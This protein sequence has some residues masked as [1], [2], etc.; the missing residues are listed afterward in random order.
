[1]KHIFRMA[2]IAAFVASSAASNAQITTLEWLSQTIDFGAFNEENGRVT[3]VLKAV[4]TGNEPLV[5]LDA[6]ANCG[7][8]VP[9]Y[10]PEPVAPGDTVSISVSYDPQG[11]P[12]RFSKKVYVDTNTE[13]S[14]S[15]LTIKGVVIGAPSSVSR[16][17]PV[18]MGPVSFERPTALLGTAYKGHVKSVFMQGYNHSTRTL[19][20]KVKC[21]VS[22]VDVATVQDSVGP[23]EQFSLNFFI[24]PDRTPLYGVVADTVYIVP[25]V[26]NPAESFAMPVVV[27]L[28]DDFSKITEEELA[29]APQAVYE[30]STIHLGKM[31]A[32]KEVTAE[33]FI[34]N[35]GKEPLIIRRVYSTNPTAEFTLD[36][37]K[38]K[39]GKSGK[40]IVSAKMPEDG[41]LNLRITAITNDPLNPTTIL[42]LT[43]EQY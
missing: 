16:R 14:R 1:M 25:E 18:E 7:C 21:A 30:N 27:T 29:R 37:K 17:Y 34:Q 12:G 35:K 6:R 19:R 8:T 24:S 32:G 23:G 15:T 2:A 10:S 28:E 9:A 31:E 39:S 33:F 43:A 3:A 20:P 5:V 42:R 4:N 38:I 11:R 41:P 26:A 13:P 36:P 40:I 22:W